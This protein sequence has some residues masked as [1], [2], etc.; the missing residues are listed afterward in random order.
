MINK[1]QEQKQKILKNNKVNK[2]INKYITRYY[3][4]NKE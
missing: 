2:Q 3:N 1:R 4:N